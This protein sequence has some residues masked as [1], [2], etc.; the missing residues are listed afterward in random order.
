MD[1]PFPIDTSTAVK[2]YRTKLS[3]EHFFQHEK[4]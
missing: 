1:M 4:N 2:N 3:F